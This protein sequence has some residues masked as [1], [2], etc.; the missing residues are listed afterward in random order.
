MMENNRKEGKIRNRKF[1]LPSAFMFYSLR[2][3][4]L[5]PVLFVIL[6]AVGLLLF[7]IEG[8]S[9]TY[10]VLNF[11]LFF[12]S[13]LCFSVYLVA[14]L[15]ELKGESYTVKA[16]ILRVAKRTHRIFFL[17]LAYFLI[18][19]LVLSVAVLNP[20]VIMPLVSIPFIVGYL[21]FMLNICYVVDLNYP[22]F[23][24]FSES[25][26]TIE[27]YK[28]SIIR[29]AFM[30]VFPVAVCSL[31]ILIVASLSKNIYIF[32]AVLYFVYIVIRFMLLRFKA[33]LFYDIE[34]RHDKEIDEEEF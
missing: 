34:Y 5:T 9:I 17:S 25:K 26:D 4:F 10:I 21:L 27:G 16:C 28:S 14:Y 32:P 1:Y 23:E 33:L 11:L 31:F 19:S 3:E 13:D 8:R 2:K 24:S 15:R 6:L 12:I 22:M 7:F 29:I 20:L 18:Y 30:F